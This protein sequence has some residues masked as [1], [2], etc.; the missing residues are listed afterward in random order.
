MGF[1][2]TL[3]FITVTAWA[4]TLWLGLY[5]SAEPEFLGR[6]SRTHLSFVIVAGA[7]AVLVTTTH[8]GRLNR[9]LRERSRV[10]ALIAFSSLLSLAGAEAIVRIADPLGI[11]YYTESRRYMLDKLADDQLYQR[12]TPNQHATYDGVEVIT[13]EIGLRERAIPPKADD[14]FRI[15]F[16]GDS[17][18]FGWGVEVEKTFV[19]RLEGR[20]QAHTRKRLRTINSGVGAYNSEMEYA[21]L[22]RHGGEIA[23]DMV[24]LV[25]VG[26]DTEAT[27]TQRYDPW[28]DTALE[29][30][31]PSKFVRLLVWKSWLY[32]LAQH[33]WKARFHW[34]AQASPRADPPREPARIDTSIPRWRASMRAITGMADFCRARGIPFVTFVFRLDNS[35]PWLAGVELEMKEMAAAQGFFTSDVLPFYEGRVRREVTNSVVDQ[36]PNA[37][38]H[39][40]LAQGI[41]GFLIDAELIP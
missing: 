41:E 4:L 9:W 30:R 10:M 35:N 6:Y 31:Y 38:G 14:E 27:P 37:L 40:L 29:P 7:L 17:I 1:R 11:S 22:K 33:G 12:H 23:P 19:R 34:A 3:L 36:H 24:V 18:T 16:L 39:D 20:L 21:F 8:V 13:N 25:F 2:S 32:R 15:L 5:R 26:N 28:S